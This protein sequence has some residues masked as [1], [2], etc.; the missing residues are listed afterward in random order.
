MTAIK[1]GLVVSSDQSSLY[2]NCSTFVINRFSTDVVYDVPSGIPCPFSHD[3]REMTTP[4]NS[5]V[6][7]S[8]FRLFEV[9][10]PYVGKD[11]NAPF[12]Y[13]KLKGPM[14]ALSLGVV[15]AYQLFFKKGAI[16]GKKDLGSDKFDNNEISEISE[17]LKKSFQKKGQKITPKMQS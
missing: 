15:F 17:S 5:L 6:L 9:M 1:G 10:V 8:D 13:S 4:Q 11:P 16:F 14:T 3:L 12:D 2:F 7:G